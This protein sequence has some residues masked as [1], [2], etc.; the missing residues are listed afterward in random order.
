MLLS[1]VLSL[2]E[3]FNCITSGN[4]G[5]LRKCRSKGTRFSQLLCSISDWHFEGYFFGFPPRRQVEHD[6]SNFSVWSAKW[7]ATQRRKFFIIP[8]QK[9]LM[10]WVSH[11]ITLLFI[12]PE[13]FIWMS[14]KSHLNASLHRSGCTV[15]PTYPKPTARLKIIPKNHNKKNPTPKPT[16]FTLQKPL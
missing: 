16:T 13:Q 15:L 7:K 10:S 2:K 11:Q 14:G 9:K 6:Y 3:S 12:L 1:N 4:N 5:Q 8:P